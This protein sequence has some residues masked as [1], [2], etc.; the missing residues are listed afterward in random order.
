VYK[1]VFAITIESSGCPYVVGDI[2]GNGAMNGIDVSYGVNYLKGGAAPPNVCDCGAYGQ[3]FAAG[4]V[5]G[6]CSFNGIDISYFV[7]F[8]KG[9]AGLLF[10]PDCPPAGAAAVVRPGLGQPAR[11]R[12][13]D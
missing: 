10:C 6:T 13:S 1:P 12:V 9:G 11:I 2:N 4:D 8:L 5:N 7:N 3:I